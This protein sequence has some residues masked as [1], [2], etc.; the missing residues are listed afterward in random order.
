MESNYLAHYGVLGMKWGVRKDPRGLDSYKS[1][2]Q[3]KWEKKREKAFQRTADDVLRGKNAARS[4][5]K[6]A[7]ADNK[8][9]MFKER[10]RRRAE[11]AKQTSSGRSIARS[12]L[13][14][15]SFNGNYHRYRA[16]GMS[17]GMSAVLAYSFGVPV[18]YLYERNAAKQAVKSRPGY[19]DSRDVK[20]SV[21]SVTANISK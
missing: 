9:E 5:H 2:G 13:M 20:R 6:A 16:T 1:H 21:R 3:K 19:V 17:E 14:G 10:D 12:L 11:Y 8:L 15:P 4:L 7:K 18:S